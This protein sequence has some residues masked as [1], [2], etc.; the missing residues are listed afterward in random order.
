MNGRTTY[1]KPEQEAALCAAGSPE[2]AMAI[3]VLVRTGM[4]PGIE[5]AALSARH[6]KDE[7]E[8][9]Q[10][11]FPANETKTKKKPR[12]IYII[13]REIIAIVRKQVELHPSGPIF[14]S[15]RETAWTQSNLSKRFRD[16]R[17]SWPKRG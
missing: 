16:A 17:T 15:P 2:L 3:K 14:T 8:R 7:G 11:V 9:M 10:I 13:D 4:R 5:F 1:L 6:V 12:T